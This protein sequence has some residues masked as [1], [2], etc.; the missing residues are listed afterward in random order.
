LG[1]VDFTVEQAL[2]AGD[3]VAQMHADDAIVDFAATA[4][5]L[6]RNA[7]RM[8]TALGRS[9]FVQAADGLWVSVFATDHLLAHVAQARLIPLD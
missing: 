2:K 8:V 3:A 7:D 4:Q 9:R 1:Q 5:P 6:P